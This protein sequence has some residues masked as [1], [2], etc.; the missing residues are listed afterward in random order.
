MLTRRIL[1]AAAFSGLSS[2]SIAQGGITDI[3]GLYTAHGMNADGSSYTGQVQIA[4]HGQS[5]AMTWSI[6]S[7]SYQGQG[8]LDGRI[9]TVDWGAATPVVYVL[10]GNELHGTWNGGTALEKLTPR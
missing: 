3:S 6:G 10:M 9:L 7:S 1:L 5:V 4:Q 2:A 8:R